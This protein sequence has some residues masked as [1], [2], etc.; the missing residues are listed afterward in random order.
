MSSRIAVTV[1]ALV[2]LAGCGTNTPSDSS[3]KTPPASASAS[4]AASPTAVGPTFADLTQGSKTSVVKLYSYDGEAHS[5]VVEPIIFMSGPDFCKAFKLKGADAP[6]ENDWASKDSHTKVT[7][8]VV[9][10]PKLLTWDGGAADEN[11][12]CVGTITSGGVCPI[13]ATKFT[14]W[15]NENPQAF[16]V[17]TMVKGT[18]TKIAQMYTP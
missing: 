18:V 16:A 7:V 6:C 3:W 9:A 17:V 1:A 12:D 14:K 4:V 13:S 5:A 10:N 2:L 8:P 15:S 11:G